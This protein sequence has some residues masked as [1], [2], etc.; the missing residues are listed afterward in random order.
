LSSTRKTPEH[1]GSA[2]N[3]PKAAAAAEAAEA[4]AEAAEAAEAVAEAAEA[5]EAA[6]A[7][8]EAAAEEAAASGARF[9]WQTSAPLTAGLF[10]SDDAH[11]SPLDVP[12]GIVI[13]GV[14]P[15]PVSDVSGKR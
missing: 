1:A 10:L 9:C 2:N 3:R 5:A 8:A 4:A 13:R 7:A 14:A 15:I 6:A 11:R 12:P